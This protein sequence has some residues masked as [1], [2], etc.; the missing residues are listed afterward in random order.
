MAIYKRGKVY[1]F[2]FIFEGR[3]VQL[4]TKTSD[5]KAARE[6][7]AAYKVKL[8]KREVDLDI[9]KKIIPMFKEAMESFLEWSRHEHAAKPNTYKRYV[10]SSKALLKFFKSTPLDKIQS[11][12]VERFKVW[13]IKQNCLTKTGKETRKKI[14]PATVNRECACLKKLFNR[15]KS[16][17]PNNPVSEVK[18]LAENNEQLRVLSL[19]EEKAYLAKASQ[20]LKDVAI[21]M[22]AMGARPEEIYKIRVKDINFEQGYLQIPFG[23]TKAA[24]R[25]LPLSEKATE[26]LKA[27]VK[28]AKGEFIF[29]SG[30]GGKDATKPIVKLNNAHYGA[31]ERSGIEKCTIYSFRHTFATRA[32]EAGIDLVTLKD[33][34]GHSR[35]DMVTR[36]A[37]PTK[38]HQFNA[39][40]K[41]ES[42]VKDKENKARENGRVKAKT[43]V[44]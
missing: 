8:A 16:I 28:A 2:N 14:K 31:L 27:R 13:R 36:Y 12:D 19:A 32:A 17:I 22:L 1:W 11:E 38:E 6:I 41:L 34:L 21:L 29:A 4:S 25:K 15:Y 7:E 5:R 42:F 9:E 30:R 10:T 33:L 35:L 43:V 18:F 37:H 20:P 24:R 40:K 26:I 39:I 44:C 3:K 23:K